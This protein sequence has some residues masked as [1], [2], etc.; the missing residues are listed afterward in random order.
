MWFGLGGG[1][2]RAPSSALQPIYIVVFI[3]VTICMTLMFYGGVA[4]AFGEIE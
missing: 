2:S 1:F 4:E 3:Q